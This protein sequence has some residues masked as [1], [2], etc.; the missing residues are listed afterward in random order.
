MANYLYI[1]PHIKISYRLFKGRHIGIIFLNGFMSDKN[2]V[3]CVNVEKYC[4]ENKIN[5][6]CFDYYGHGESSGEPYDVTIGSCIDSTLNVIDRL[7][8]GPQLLVASSAG[9]W[10]MNLVAQERNS[11]IAGMIGF[12]NAPDFTKY[13]MWDTFSDAIKANLMSG[14][15]LETTEFPIPI[16]YKFIEESRKHFILE[17]NLI[18]DFP[19]VLL[20]G[21][22]DTRVPFQ[23]SEK[24][25]ACYCP[26]KAYLKLIEDATHSFDRQIDIIEITNTINKLRLI[27][28][29]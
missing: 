28:S 19:V 14:M 29:F 21:K 10:I 22:A 16:T 15:A 6:L 1:G 9:G 7:T 25:L 17:K 3:R 4:K 18:F 24:L 13:L 20:H 26:D 12:S 11:R 2:N 27:F 5:F 23:Y 8:E